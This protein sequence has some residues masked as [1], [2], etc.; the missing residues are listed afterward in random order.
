MEGK[1]IAAEIVEE[2][3]VKPNVNVRCPRVEGLPDGEV[4]WEIN[5]Q[6]QEKLYGMIEQ[7]QGDDPD[8]TDVT[9]DWEVRVNKNSVLSL[10]FQ[11][12]SY[13][14]GAAHGMTL[15]K[16]LTFDLESGRVYQLKDMFKPGVNYVRVLNGFIQRQIKEREIPIISEFRSI[17]HDQDFYLTGEALVIYFQLYQYTPYAYGIP[18]F[19]LPYRNMLELIDPQGPIARLVDVSKPVFIIYPG[20]QMKVNLRYR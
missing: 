11:V 12:D 10:R 18:E 1:G 19:G 16:S 20:L 13:T 17:S 3:I 15:V 5:H 7:Q 8:E 4:E 6:V 9:G 14:E 2:R